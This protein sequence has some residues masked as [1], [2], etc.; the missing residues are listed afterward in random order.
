MV[1][2]RSQAAM[3]AM[4]GKLSFGGAALPL[5]E[6]VKIPGV[7]VDRGLRFDS[8]RRGGDCS[9]QQGIGAKVPHLAGL[10]HPLR[11]STHST[12]TVLNG[13]DAVE[14]PRSQGCQHQRIFAGHISRMWNLFTAAVPHVQE[15]NTHSVK[16]MAHKWKQTLPT[17]LTLIMT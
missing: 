5:Q 10:H 17:P 9:V 2:S 1:V 3:A 11:A 13:G 15:M 6:D 16:L 12:R 8:Q 14:V 4:A 7:Q